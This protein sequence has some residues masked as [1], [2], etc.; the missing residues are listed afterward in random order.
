MWHSRT[1][2]GAYT[3]D[4]VGNLFQ[5]CS[6]ELDGGSI[7]PAINLLRRTST[8]N[9]SGLA[10]PGDRPCHRNRRHGTAVPLRDGAESV[11]QC[12][13]A[14]QIRRLKLGGAAPPIIG[15]ELRNAISAE[16]VR[17]QA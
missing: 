5:I 11:S 2:A 16:I 12:K 9:G 6:G 1:G 10:R 4:S 14:A 3:L 15:R 17:Q 7:D 13:V 8:H